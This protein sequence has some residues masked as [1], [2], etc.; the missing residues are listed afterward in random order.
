MPDRSLPTTRP[1]T[2]LF[3]RVVTILEQARTNVVRTVNSQMVIAYWL[4]GCEIVEEEQQGQGRAEYGARLIEKLSRQLTERYGKGFSVPNLK[5]FR[6]FYVTYLDRQPQIPYTVCRELSGCHAVRAADAPS[7][8]IG[9][10]PHSEMERDEREKSYTVCSESLTASE[11]TH[12]HLSDA[13]SWS[14]YRLLMRV[15]NE[16][17]R[18]FYEIEAESNRWS[19]RQLER[20]INSLLFE[21]LAKS[22]DKEGVLQLANQGQRVEQPIDVMKDP[23][24]LEFLNLPESHKLTETDIEAALITHLQDFLLEL[25]S[26]FA[27]VGRQRRLTLDGDHYYPDLVFYHVKLKCYVV[28]DLKT[29]KLTPADLGQML[30][31]V[32]YYDREV[33]EPDDNPTVGLVLCTDRNEAMVEYVLDDENRRIFASRYQLYLPSVDDLR[34]ELVRELELC[35]AYAE[36]RAIPTDAET[37][38]P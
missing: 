31:Y 17:A 30:L 16:R 13:L 9:D 20:Q 33:R 3:E 32:H 38:T 4:I 2:P 35:E 28:I 37:A 27:F 36:Y 12:N 1:Q 25:G 10:A 5:N 19:V 7:C 22:R 21:R 14:H 6:K 15:T 8:K 23:V 24:V 34:R 29:G 11:P 18:S 26:G